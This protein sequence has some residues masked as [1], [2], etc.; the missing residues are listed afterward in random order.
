MSYRVKNR[1]EEAA[2][3][4]PLSAIA[5]LVTFGA[6]SAGHAGLRPGGPYQSVFDPSGVISR[7]PW[8]PS[9]WMEVQ[10]QPSRYDP[11][12]LVLQAGLF[13]KAGGAGG[14]PNK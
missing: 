3:C 6:T 9:N 5:A 1:T 13:M 4:A 2:K 7:L 10:Y 12:F 8:K 11:T 14:R